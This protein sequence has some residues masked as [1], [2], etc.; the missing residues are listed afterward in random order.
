MG[1]QAMPSLDPLFP[2]FW[3]CLSSNSR[4]PFPCVVPSSA[5]NSAL[6]MEDKRETS[7]KA[8][9]ERQCLADEAGESF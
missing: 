7:R 6:L 2:V 4:P 3:I 9:G 5:I 1:L 8:Q